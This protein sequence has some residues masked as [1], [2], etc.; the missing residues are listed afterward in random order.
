MDPGITLASTGAPPLRPQDGAPPRPSSTAPAPRVSDLRVRI[1]LSTY[2]GERYL[3]ELLDSLDAQSHRRI[4]LEVRDDGSS[5][6]TLQILD[7]YARRRP[8]SVHRGAHLGVP[9]SF[10]HLLRD[11]GDEADL[12]GFCDQDDVWLPHKVEAA[13]E[14]LSRADPAVPSM[15]CSAL[16]PVDAE[17]HPL[18][19]GKPAGEVL[20]FR[21]ALVENRASGCTMVFN[22]AARTLLTRHLPS[23]AQMHDHWAYLVVSAFGGVYYDPRPS[24][25]YRQHGQ[26]RVGMPRGWGSKVRRFRNGRGMM[27][28]FRQAEEF[29]ALYGDALHPELR[30]ALDRFLGSRRGLASRLGYALRAETYRQRVTDDVLHRL[31]IAL[32]LY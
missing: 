25:L 12:Y 31:M 28:I 26:N 16:T 19:G 3:P 24:L 14:L 10:F 20:G 30:A 15:Y 18:P 6:R 2:N 7:D 8:A 9:A 32:G 23:A 4:H 13:V 29:R 17:L 5:D 11:A 22:H 21:N 27:P 1:L